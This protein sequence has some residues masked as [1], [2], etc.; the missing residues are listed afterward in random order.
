M[1]KVAVV[2][3]GAMGLPMAHTLVRKGLTVSGYDLS[4]DRRAAFEGAVQSLEELPNVDAVLLSLPHD[5]A[6]DA[7]VGT[8]VKHLHSGSVII[9]TSTIAPK[10]ARAMSE[11]AKLAGI[12][13]LDAPVSGGA[14]GAASGSLLMMIGGVAQ[15]VERA[16]PVTSALTNAVVHCG[17]PGAGAV[18]KL[19]NNLLCA[20][21]LV[22]AGEALRL[23]EAGGVAPDALLEAVNAGSGRSGVTEVNLPKWVLS[24]AFDSAFTTGLMAKDVG[25]A[26]GA[27]GAGPIAAELAAR[28]QAA[29]TDLGAEA[30][31]NRIVEQSQ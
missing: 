25:L 9:D 22:L 18:V 6:V 16:A 15:D 26:A 29:A 11:S 13:Y 2:G 14:A 20:G 3:L 10:T 8:L 23:A 4:M 31:F 30:D 21:H 19:A 5:A 27:E 12:G 1:D 7:T 24:G 28:W 17:G